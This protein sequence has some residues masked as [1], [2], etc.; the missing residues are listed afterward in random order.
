MGN[1]GRV[2]RPESTPTGINLDRTGTDRFSGLGP[3]FAGNKGATSM[4]ID[5]HTH[6]FAREVREDRGRYFPD[7]PAFQ[8]LYESPKSKLVGAGE[9]VAAMDKDGVDLSVVFG[10]PWRDLQACKRHND[11]I[12][13]AV[14][15]YP[16]RLVG[17]CCVDPTAAGAPEEV[18]RC[19]DAGL[20]GVGELAFY[21]SGIDESALDRLAP[22]MDLCRSRGLPV[23]L[24]TNEPVGHLYPGKT[25]VTPAQIYRLAERFPENRLILAHWGG[26]IF[27]F[28]LL[29]K[30]ARQRLA[31][32]YYDTAASPYLYDPRIYRIAAEL[33]G[34]D[35]ILFGSDYPLLHPKRYF[36]E[37]ADAGLPDDL[38]DRICGGN[39]GALLGR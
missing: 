30:E 7:E 20:S 21:R 33:G 26:G 1:G 35:R 16:T 31:N 29:K 10:F 13:A 28:N 5:F 34:E 11:Y 15:R 3:V 14:A 12:L 25:P 36:Q 18:E 23:L 19:L 39:A 22:I 2:N 38:R 6:I 9:I 37:M 17:F 8:L 32:L 27:F 24:H 4:I